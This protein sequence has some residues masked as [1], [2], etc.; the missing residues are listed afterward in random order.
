LTR[1]GLSDRIAGAILFALALWFWWRAGTY[2]VAFGDPAGP[3][4][5]PRVIAVPLAVLSLW[6]VLRPD[7]NP[8]WFRFPAVLKQGVA[9]ACLFAYPYL[10]VPLGFP[11]ATFLAALPLSLLF[12]ATWLQGTITA[13]CLGVG[14][15]FT[16]DLLF[17]LPLPAGPLFGG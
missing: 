15:F 6:L 13:A 10:I 16:F 14:L 3:S 17:G 11:I 2:T 7:E 9:L 8:T 1:K 5:F 12:G 4:L